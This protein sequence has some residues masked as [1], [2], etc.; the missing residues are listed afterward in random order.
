MLRCL[1]LWATMLVFAGCATTSTQPSATLPV[2]Q[3]PPSLM[4][5]GTPSLPPSSVPRPMAVSRI[6]SDESDVVVL[7]PTYHW[8]LTWFWNMAGDTNAPATMPYPH[9]E[10]DVDSTTDLQNGPW[11]LYCRTNQPAV[12]FTSD[13]DQRFFRVG[14]HCVDPITGEIGLIY[15]DSWTSQ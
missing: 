7:P 12:P 13:G 3:I 9:I 11:S 5:G 6:A 4:P 10:F 2:A 15:Y 14:V 1:L 8:N